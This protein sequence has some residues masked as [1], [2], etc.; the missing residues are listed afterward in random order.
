MRTEQT[1]AVGSELSDPAVS[2]DRL[3]AI[4][5]SV[6][7][8][9]RN[10]LVQRICGYIVCNEIFLSR[11]RYLG[12]DAADRRELLHEV[13]AVSRTSSSSSSSSS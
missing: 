4:Y 1:V 6:M 10:S 8:V 12:D 13:R 3:S 7:L 5:E 11:D 9:I 2:I